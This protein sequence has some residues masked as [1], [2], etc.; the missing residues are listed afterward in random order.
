MKKFTFK[1]TKMLWTLTI[2]LLMI[3]LA[4]VAF[5]VFNL[6]KLSEFGE[7]NIV[8]Y[9]ILLAVNVALLVFCLSLLFFRSYEISDEFL[10]TRFGIL[11]FKA[12]IKDVVEIIIYEN[13]HKLV[14]YFADAKYSVIIIDE[15]D[16]DAFCD[17][18]KEK[19][20]SVCVS[21]KSQN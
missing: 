20:P 13:Q 12:K 7:K 9:S 6:V 2:A 3:A 15:N 17:A 5:N 19:N 18:I 10:T 4:G 8:T 16:Y 21:K 11:K 1:Y 14:T